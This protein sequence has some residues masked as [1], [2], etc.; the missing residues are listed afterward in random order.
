MRMGGFKWHASTNPRPSQ[1][2]D[3]QLVEI[4]IE[5]SKVSMA[6]ILSTPGYDGADGEN[7]VAFKA[8]L[9]GRGLSDQAA[10]AIANAQDRHAAMRSHIRGQ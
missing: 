7:P 10:E 5:E 3:G 9:Q 4:T 6:D 1:S 8:W 2:P